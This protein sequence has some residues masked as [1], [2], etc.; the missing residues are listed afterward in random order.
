MTPG[1][2]NNVFVNCPFDDGYRAKL[3]AIVYVIYRCGFV[4]HSALE[5]D[6]ASD[7]RLDKI[8]RCIE[9]CKYGIHDI[10]NIELNDEGF[11]RFNMPFE[12]G[13]FFGAKRFG[14]N[15]QK[16]KNALVFERTKFTYQK[17]ISDLNGIDTKAHKD[18][19]NVI[20]KHVRDWLKTASKRKSIPW[21]STIQNDYQ[22]F[23]TR[24]P[25][26]AAIATL[27]IDTM[28]FADYC[29]VVEE[30]IAEILN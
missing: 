4:P 19:I 27:D 3:N 15:E 25:Q 13:I 8:V 18:D 6:D 7:N 5:E 28:T 23:V 20:I 16:S 1:Y 17:Y 12:L 11:P 10:S 9:Q 24:L 22:Q 14:N 30:A 21:A 2:S 26:I 29:Q